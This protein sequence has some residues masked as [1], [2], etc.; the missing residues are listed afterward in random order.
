LERSRAHGKGGFAETGAGR[1]ILGKKRKTL[2][3]RE[4]L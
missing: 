1:T 4:A 2:C 3:F